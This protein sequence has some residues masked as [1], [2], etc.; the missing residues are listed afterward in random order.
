MNNNV[1]FCFGYT[2]EDLVKDVIANNG[3]SHILECILNEKKNG[4]CNCKT[5]HPEGR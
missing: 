3:I 4:A 2:E 1:C 5:R